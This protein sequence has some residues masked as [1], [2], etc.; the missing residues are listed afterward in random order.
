MHS[1]AYSVIISVCVVL[2]FLFGVSVCLLHGI[3]FNASAWVVQSSEL[4]QCIARHSLPLAI[5]AMAIKRMT[6][7]PAFDIHSMLQ[8]TICIIKSLLLLQLR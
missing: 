6:L 2:S 7:I 4:L 8:C 3:A 5:K 1:C